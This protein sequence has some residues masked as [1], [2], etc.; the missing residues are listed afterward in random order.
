MTE[1]TKDPASSGI[2]R[3]P[4]LFAVLSSMLLMLAGLFILWQR[5]QILLDDR[6]SSMSAM[7]E[8]VEQNIDQSLKYS[9]SAA[10]SLALQIDNDGQIENFEEVAA[11][12]IDNNT[13]IDAIQTVPKGVITKV[14]PYEENKEAINYNILKDPA[15]RDEALEAIARKRMFF[16]GPFELK[17]GGLAI[18]GRLPVFIKDDFWGFV[19]VL[20][21]FDNLIAQSGISEL[22][23]KDYSFQFS[24]VNPVSGEEDFFL[25]GITKLEDSYSEDIEVSDGNWKIYIIPQDIWGPFYELIPVAFLILLVGGALGWIVYHALKEPVILENRVRMQAG[26]LAD[27]EHRFRTIFNQAA[28]GMARVDSRTGK[29]LETNKRFQELIGYSEEELT[30][31]KHT[32]FSHPEDIDSN[33]K[34][35]QKLRNNE[36][37]EYHLSKRLIRKNGKVI[38][39]NLNVSPLWAEGEEATSHIALVEDISSRVEAK[40]LLKDNENRFR[41]LVENSNEIILIVD[42]QNSVKYASPSLGKVTNYQKIDFSVNG[43][44]HYVHPD[45]HDMLREKIEY[46]YTKPGIPIPDI[47][48]KVI[49]ADN[50]W[51]WVN[52][53]LTNMLDADNINGFVINLRNITEKREAELNLV[54]SYELVMEQNKRLLNFAY[55]VSHN[56]RSHASNMEAILDLYDSEDSEEEKNNFIGL[57]K[58]VSKNLDQSLRDL[59]EVVSINT[60][61]DLKVEPISVNSVLGQTLEMLSLQINARNAEVITEVPDGMIV[62]FNSAYIESVLL[63]F[64]TNAL[65][66]SHEERDSVI[67]IKG[68][69]EENHWVLEIKDNGI[70]IDLKRHGDKLFGL[71]KT[72]S[73]RKDARG[74]GLF[75]TKNQINAMGGDVEVESE[76]GIGTTFKVI[77]K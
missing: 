49:D 6:K 21:K 76:V 1:Q 69:K 14:Y 68:Y 74:V 67:W 42:D 59:N 65:R 7:I 11:R 39:I 54:K 15:R 62:H 37:R 77:F 41:S 9:Y 56:L 60:N 63:N 22:S 19:A 43:V 29:V 13:N 3:K 66:Y 2:I 8:V 17:Q 23:G 28:I 64:I 12:I 32:D 24:K 18:V 71:Y 34:L 44:L 4:M 48:L 75:I 35:M 25:D 31:K 20:I 36:I 16:A 55:I 10:L 30:G 27:S 33:V 72:F 58:K 52:L 38:W 57:L 46:A 5:Y 26:E 73:G 45:Y 40:Q 53:T 50:Q 61:M 47:I 70:G 51:F